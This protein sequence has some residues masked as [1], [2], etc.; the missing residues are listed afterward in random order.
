MLAATQN[1]G[2]NDHLKMR[3]KM[4]HFSG[5]RPGDFSLPTRQTIDPAQDSI[6]SF[7]LKLFP[8]ISTVSE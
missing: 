5:A 6:T 4:L 8:S 3:G 1:C 2:K 7:I